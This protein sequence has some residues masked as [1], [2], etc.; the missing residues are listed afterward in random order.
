MNKYN[1]SS[2]QCGTD[3]SHWLSGVKLIELRMTSRRFVGIGESEGSPRS[4][5]DSEGDYRILMF[6]YLS[7]AL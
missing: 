5:P 6:G 1:L 3:E 4:Q 7:I 2:F